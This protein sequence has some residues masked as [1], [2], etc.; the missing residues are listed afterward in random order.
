M[1]TENFGNKDGK[2]KFEDRLQRKTAN[3]KNI[4][5]IHA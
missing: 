3:M 4:F 2:L 1:R 5:K